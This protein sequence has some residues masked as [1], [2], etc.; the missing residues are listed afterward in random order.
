MQQ[1]IP[2]CRFISS[3]LI[4]DRFKENERNGFCRRLGEV[5]SLQDIAFKKLKNKNNYIIKMYLDNPLSD[6]ST[7]DSMHNNEIGSI[8]IANYLFENIFEKYIFNNNLENKF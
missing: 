4:I 3:S 7:I 8:Q 1:D 2:G 6:K 5:Y